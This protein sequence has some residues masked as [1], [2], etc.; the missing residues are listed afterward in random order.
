M[1]KETTSFSTY[2]PLT[3]P[4]RTVWWRG[5]PWRGE[6]IGHTYSFSLSEFQPK[7]YLLFC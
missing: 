1:Q 5:D 6:A 2:V 7:N 4:R 3:Y